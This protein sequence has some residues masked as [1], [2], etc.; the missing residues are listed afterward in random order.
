[1]SF[2]C[3]RGVTNAC[4]SWSFVRLIQW[5]HQEHNYVGRGMHERP[6]DYI[7]YVA[8][9][10]VILAAKF[11]FTYFLQE[12]L[13]YVFSLCSPTYQ[14]QFVFQNDFSYADSTSR[15]TNKTDYQFQRLTVSVA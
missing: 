7:K 2:P 8:F 3:C 6:L 9:W 5:M 1:M 15:G 12:S 14:H 11:S 4:Y 13:V 10:L